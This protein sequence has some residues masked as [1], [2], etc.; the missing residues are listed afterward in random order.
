MCSAQHNWKEAMGHEELSYQL[1]KRRKEMALSQGALADIAGVSRNYVALIEQGKAQNVSLDIL[2]RLASAMGVTL[3][4]L[5]GET[6]PKDQP[7]P[8]A[9]RELGLK[10][11]LSFEVVDKLARIP[12]R[13]LEPQTVAEWRRLYRA[14]RP[15][16]ESPPEQESEGRS[17][18]QSA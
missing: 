4:E 10:E 15:Y 5:I 2:T 7:I 12:K 16:L 18:R 8:T 6:E 11:E 1:A 13:G 3:A 17:Q 9:L 14:V